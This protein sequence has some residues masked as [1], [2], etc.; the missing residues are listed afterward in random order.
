MYI[1]DDKLLNRN[2]FFK[3]CNSTLG[4]SYDYNKYSTIQNKT[5]Q[6][7]YIKNKL[8]Y[9]NMFKDNM[10]N[11]MNNHMNISIKTKQKSNLYKSNSL[12]KF[13]T[14]YKCFTSRQSRGTNVP[15]QFQR[16]LM[17]KL[18]KK[19]DNNSFTKENK[20][21]INIKLRTVLKNCK[22]QEDLGIKEKKDFKNIPHLTIRERMYK[23][24][25]WDNVDKSTL[26]NQRDALM[27]E[28]FQYY[29]TL[30][31]KENKKYFDNNYIIRKQPDLKTIPVLVRDIFKER[32]NESDIF[33]K[34]KNIKKE[35]FEN[36]ISKSKEKAMEEFYSSDIFN[37]KI[38]PRIIKKSGEYAYFKKRKKK[39]DE[40]LTYNKNTESIR[41]WGVRDPIPSLLNY[42]SS[43]YNPINPAIKNFCKT[44]DNII[45]EC[46]KKCKGYNPPN[47]QKSL[48]EFI[49][50]TNV[51]ASNYNN[52]Y[53]RVLNQNPNAFK[54]NDDMFSDYYNLYSKYKS[55]AQKP[56]YKFCPS[57]IK[58]NNDFNNI[59]NMSKINQSVSQSSNS[60][61]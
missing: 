19:F 61:F 29:E 54:K 1:I 16:N 48:S 52:D 8:K 34:N 23:P 9:E 22:S 25:L 50:L 51:N 42:S 36:E 5:S 39:I 2:L 41:G 32:I 26:T 28:G 35:V 7:L 11:N 47:K 17:P 21:D 15:L 18:F 40:H 44:K 55:I 3:R 37:K 24:Y 43:N 31:E 27:P 20:E 58:N 13:S 53:N 14:Q 38:N 56:F 30:L 60:N 59:Y 6:P 49:D 4:N 57:I 12:P 10:N 46:N 33:F 45:E